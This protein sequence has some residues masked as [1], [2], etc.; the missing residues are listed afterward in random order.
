MKRF[1]F[2]PNKSGVVYR[3]AVPT[4]IRKQIRKQIGG[5]MGGPIIA[6]R[7]AATYNGSPVSLLEAVKRLR[8]GAFPAPGILEGRSQASRNPLPTPSEQRRGIGSRQTW[9]EPW[10]SKLLR[11]LRGMR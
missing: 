2:L 1:S 7:H 5:Q 11:A 9:K 4:V 8:A 10:F 6:Q 3:P